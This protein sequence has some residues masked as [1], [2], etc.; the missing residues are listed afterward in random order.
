MERGILIL[1]PTDAKPIC[2]SWNIGKH[3]SGMLKLKKG[4]FFSSL[5]LRITECKLWDKKRWNID[6][7]FVTRVFFSILQ[8]ALVQIEYGKHR[9]WGD[10]LIEWCV[11]HKILV[12]RTLSN[13]NCRYIAVTRPIKY[14]K[15]KNN[16]RVW[17]TILLVW[18]ISAAIG[19]PIV[20]GLNNTP[21]RTPDLCM[22]YNTDFIMYSSLSSFLIPCIIMIFLYYSIFK[23][24]E[25]IGLQVIANSRNCPNVDNREAQKTKNFIRGTFAFARFPT[26]KKWIRYQIHFE[27]DRSVHSKP[28]NPLATKYVVF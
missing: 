1:Y 12:Q 25:A 23:V 14:A 9:F 5:R 3:K 21:D 7:K 11:G 10:I 15:H 19:S 6:R 22:F 28:S 27:S 8:V 13:L 18:A 4:A 26:K 24:S 16:R 20:L 2:K 17:L